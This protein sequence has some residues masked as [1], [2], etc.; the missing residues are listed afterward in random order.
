MSTDEQFKVLLEKRKNEYKSWQ[1]MYCQAI[2]Q[3]VYFDKKGFN[4]L[5]FKIDNTPR[6][7]EEAMY[8]LG[9]L[10]LVKPVIY[11]ATSA[12]YQRRIS[13]VGGTRT[14]VLKEIEYWGITAIVG[15]QNVKVR[16]ILRKLVNGQKIHFWSVMKL[17]ENQKTPS[18]DEVV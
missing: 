13:P 17:A 8:K 1:P 14:P 5:R 16:V 9:L 11:S 7:P 3:Y 12:E 10:P 18:L 15:K 4:H 2:R 6:K